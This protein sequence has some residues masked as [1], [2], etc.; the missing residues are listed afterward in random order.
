MTQGISRKPLKR[1]R[2]GRDPD[3]RGNQFLK[4]SVSTSAMTR[5]DPPCDQDADRTC[6]V[7][8]PA[9]KKILEPTRL[10]GK[11]GPQK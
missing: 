1:S 11:E 5:L 8:E 9:T 6:I 4:Q 7:K 3:G 10:F 2:S